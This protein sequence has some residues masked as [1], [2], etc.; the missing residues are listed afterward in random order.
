MTLKDRGQCFSGHHERC[1]S[2]LGIV[3]CKDIS[4][5]EWNH[6]MDIQLSSQIFIE[7]RIRKAMPLHSCFND[8]LFEALCLR[9]P[10]TSRVIK[11]ILQ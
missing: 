10:M 7:A 1:Q 11:T 6:W 5:E 8:R 2:S 3:S 9:K 4:M